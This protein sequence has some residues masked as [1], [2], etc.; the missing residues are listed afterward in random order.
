MRQLPP[1]DA[2]DLIQELPRGAARRLPRAARRARAQGG[3]GAARLRRGRRRRPDEPAL[4]ARAPRHDAS[5]RRSATCAARRASASRPSTT[6]T[7]STARSTCSASSRSASSSPRS[8]TQ[9]VR[10]VMHTDFVKVRADLDQES[11]S[12][13]IAE[14]D[15]AARARRRRGRPHAGHR[16]GRRHRRRGARGG[17]RGHPEDRRHGG[18]RRPLPPGRA[19]RDGRASARAGS[20]CSSSGEMLHDRGHGAT[21]RTR[22]RARVVLALFIPL[23]ISSGGNSGSQA[24]TLVIRAMAHGR[25]AAARLVARAAARARR[26]LAARA[27]CSARSACCASCSGRR[28]RADLRRARRCWSPSRSA[29]SLVWIVLWGALAGAMLPFVLRRL[30]FDPASASAPFVAT[31]VDVTGIVIYFSVATVLLTG[32]AALAACARE[33]SPASGIA[34]AVLAGCCADRVEPPANVIVIL[35]D[36]QGYGDVGVLRLARTSRRRTSIR[37]RRT[38][39]ASATATSARRSAR[40]RAPGC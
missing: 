23:I 33:L 38:A 31:L 19:A 39:C 14:H 37:S 9:T 12:Q 26:G 30:G 15:L 5:T 24:S 21:S 10:D 4:R 17:H 28:L 16:D 20:R 27:A 35:S 34:I 8:P 6:S 29:S 1:D 40:R 18:P 11:V 13:I 7:C 36:D 25:G 2:A 3:R 32:N 22:S